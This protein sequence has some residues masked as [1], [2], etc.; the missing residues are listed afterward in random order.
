MP[1]IDRIIKIFKD[2][3]NPWWTYSDVCKQ[4]WSEGI[5]CSPQSVSRRMQENRN[6]FVEKSVSNYKK[7]RL[8]DYD[9]AAENLDGF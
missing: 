1:L 4:L 7:F 8:K 6:L 2:N 9:V 3:L 5:D